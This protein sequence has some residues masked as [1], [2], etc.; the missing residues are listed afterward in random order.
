VERSGRGL[1]KMLSRQ[2]PVE[3]EE[4]AEKPQDSRYPCR[5][6]NA[7]PH[8]YEAELA[9]YVQIKFVPCCESQTAFGVTPLI[10]W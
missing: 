7:E 4:S 5:Y 9:L 1:F 3:A 2:L 8:D 6:S 10:Q